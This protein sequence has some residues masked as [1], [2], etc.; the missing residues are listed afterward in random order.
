MAR[1]LEVTQVAIGVRYK[2]VVVVLPV[3]GLASQSLTVGR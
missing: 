1:G 3:N 2:Q